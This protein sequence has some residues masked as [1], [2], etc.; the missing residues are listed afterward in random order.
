MKL[1]SLRETAAPVL[2]YGDCGLSLG[3][4]FTE[5]CGAF[6]VVCPRNQRKIT[7]KFGQTYSKSTRKCA[8]IVPKRWKS[9]EIGSW[10]HSGPFFR[11]TKMH[12]DC[13]L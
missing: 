13:R 2:A 11:K 9:S 8:E 5:D 12:K 1:K 3:T 6:L 7:Q 10:S 4:R